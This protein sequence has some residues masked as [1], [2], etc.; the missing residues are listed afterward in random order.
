MQQA[1]GLSVEFF[2][3]HKVHASSDSNNFDLFFPPKSIAESVRVSFTTK[4]TTWHTTNERA[5]GQA[6]N[7][8]TS[9]FN[10]LTSVLHAAHV[11][12]IANISFLLR[13]R[14]KF[15]QAVV[16]LGSSKPKGTKWPHDVARYPRIVTGLYESLHMSPTQRVF[17]G[18]RRFGKRDETTELVVTSPRVIDPGAKLSARLSILSACSRGCSSENSPPWPSPPQTKLEAQGFSQRKS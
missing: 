6:A 5:N 15:S 11:W 17:L 2:D 12:V 16:T 18:S 3:A 10:N 14:F 4:Q 13:A 8:P 1:E 7:Q 9:K